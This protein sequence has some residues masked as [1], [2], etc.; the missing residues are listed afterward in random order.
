MTR[1][2]HVWEKILTD[3]NCR[4]AVLREACTP[5]CRRNG[6]SE[7]LRGNIDRWTEYVRQRIGDGLRLG[8]FNEFPVVEAGKRRYVRCYAIEDAMCVRAA[9]Q[10]MEVV[11]YRRV[12]PRS[13]C[14][15]PGRGGLKLAIDL[16][17]MLKKLSNTCRIHNKYK[18]NGRTPWKAWVGEWDERSYY[19]SISNSLAKETLYRVF[20][21]PEILNLCEVFVGQ[22]DGIPIGAGYSAM[23]ANLILAP[24]DWQII[25]RK[26]VYGYARHLDNSTYITRSKAIA[27]DVRK[28]VE[29]WNAER[30][31]RTHGW[32]KYPAGHHAIERGGWR[33]DEMR[34]LPSERVTRH[35]IKLLSRPVDELSQEE[36]LALAS[37]YGYVKHGES[38]SLKLL[39]RERHASRIFKKIGLTAKQA[40][41]G[42]IPLGEKENNHE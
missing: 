11:A 7:E 8:P 18:S 19:D 1:E 37:L 42:P 38:L 9:V 32:A 22:R 5:R 36:T 25:E 17:R 35:I 21:E 28:M 6:R 26:G 13:Y 10:Q 23:I 2:W 41:S 20:G 30:G 16:R 4:R 33:I 3:E 31:L 14:P 39:W 40:M 29:D 15:I 27:G 24:L 34:I 12:S